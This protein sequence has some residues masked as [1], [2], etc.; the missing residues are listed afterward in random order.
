MTPLSIASHLDFATAVVQDPQVATKV[1]T[2]IE[3]LFVRYPRVRYWN[4]LGRYR[5]KI[6]TSTEKHGG[7]VASGRSSNGEVCIQVWGRET[8]K[9]LQC[10]LE[11]APVKFTRL[12]MAVT[13]LFSTPQLRVCD[14]MANIQP[15][16]AHYSIIQPNNDEGGT[17]Y[18][19]SRR[20]DVFAR[21]Y[22]KGAQLGTIPGRLLWRYEVEYKGKH[23][24]QAVTLLFAPGTL[25]SYRQ[26]SVLAHVK[27]YFEKHQVPFPDVVEAAKDYPLVQYESLVTDDKITLRWLRTQV[28]PAILRLQKN[29]RLEEALEALHVSE[30]GK[31]LEHFSLREID[32]VQGHFLDKLQIPM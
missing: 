22:D 18:V 26:A 15:G 28:F 19:G 29:G 14:V 17:L 4:F 3:H 11:N 6:A 32:I 9:M 24:Q 1:Q 20:S 13:I 2:S 30:L 31:P 10:V 25:P 8:D 16:R 12:D 21:M 5:G 23:A 27:T 7:G